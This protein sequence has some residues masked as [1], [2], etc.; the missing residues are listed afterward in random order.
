MSLSINRLLSSL[1]I[2]FIFLYLMSPLGATFN[3]VVVPDFHMLTFG[4]IGMSLGLWLFVRW[5]GGWGWHRTA[6]DLVFLLWILAFTTSV[7]GN[8][9]TVRRSLIGLWY[10][11][12]YV[13]VWYALHDL[14]SNGGITRKQLIDALLSAGILIML[15][16]VVQIANAGEFVAPV[17]LIGNTNALGAVL[18][19]MTPFAVGR[20]L[21]AEH[22]IGRIIWGL[23]SLAVIANLL[24]TLSRGAW[25]GLFASLTLLGALL[26]VHYEMLSLGAIRSWWIKRSQGQKRMLGGTGIVLTVGVAVAAG[27]L[28]NSFSVADRRPELRTRLWNA[29]LT[30]FAEK[31]IAGQGFYT[32]GH[33][34]PLSISIPPEQSHAHAHSVPLN[35]LAETGLIGFVVFIGTVIYTIRLVIKRWS[36]IKGDKRLTW[37]SA[38]ASLFGMGIHHLFDLPAMMPVVA[39]VGVLVLILVCAPYQPQL[40]TAWWRKIGH[41]IGLVVLWSVLLVSGVWSSNIYLQYLDAMRI[42]FGNREEVTETERFANYRETAIRLDDVIAQDPLMPI[43]HQQ[44]G[45]VWGFLSA[46]GDIEALQNGVD[47]Y[48]Q[49]LL[50]EPHHAISWANLSILYWHLDNVKAAVDSLDRAIELAPAYVFFRELREVYLGERDIASI[51]E[52]TYAF[53]QNFARFEFLREPL[54]TLF[55]P[56]TGQ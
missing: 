13:G 22:R 51:S 5:R 27:L 26:L 32:F 40:M 14:L 1:Y 54:A 4:L 9:E 20:F 36:T 43:Y 34:Y 37:I 46:S 3:G 35:I 12:V 39:L 55:L 48:E 7:L 23:Y 50:L 42:S 52:P 53:N 2:T 45:L 44:Q 16:S 10:M 38:I 19:A 31:P 15:F 6:F 17:S 56:L 47:A 24:L 28:L 11:L 25:L 33:D 21:T 18:V 8:M 41:P 29:A 49:F 30:Q